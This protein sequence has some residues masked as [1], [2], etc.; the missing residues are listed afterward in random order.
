MSV[1]SVLHDPCSTAL[2]LST[3]LQGECESNPKENSDLGTLHFLT[4]DGVSD[5]PALKFYPPNDDVT[6]V[7]P[8]TNTCPDDV[9]GVDPG[10]DPY[11]N[12]M[13]YNHDHC[14]FDITKGQL[15]RMTAVWE[16]YRKVTLEPT[17]A[18][19]GTLSETPS[20][21]V[22]VSQPSTSPNSSN[23][24]RS[25]ISQSPSSAPTALPTVDAI[26][27][28]PKPSMLQSTLPNDDAEC[29]PTK[30]HVFRQAMGCSTHAD[31][32]TKP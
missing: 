12:L 19:T 17:E 5:T 3:D 28:T 6:C 7:P 16:L 26:K 29:C 27:A 9:D 20:S 22:L 24:T 15:E 8:D 13:G 21:S 14:V 25:P 30:F 31:L 32:C 1:G 4:G 23:P 10:M 2:Y 18:P 11:F